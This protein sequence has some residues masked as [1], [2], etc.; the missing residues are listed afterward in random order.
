MVHRAAAL[1]LKLPHS[2]KA[3]LDSGKNDRKPVKVSNKTSQHVSNGV[4]QVPR[5]QIFYESGS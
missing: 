1:K 3:T 2:F 4:A 5:P